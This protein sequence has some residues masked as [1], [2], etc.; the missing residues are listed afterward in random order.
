[1]QRKVNLKESVNSLTELYTYVKVGQLNDHMLNVLQVKNRTLDFHIHTD[2]DEMFYV[3]EGEMQIEF[4]DSVTDLSEGD[5]IIVPKG[6]KHRP[7]VNSLVKVLLIE[8][9]GTLTIN[10]TG[11]SYSE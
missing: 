10:N 2:S 8:K 4:E 1:M 5:F 3:I 6:I 11:G 7:I 9:N